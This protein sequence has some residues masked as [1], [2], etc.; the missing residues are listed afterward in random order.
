GN[1]R[2]P[3]N[4]P[5][6]QRKQVPPIG[7]DGGGFLAGDLRPA[8]RRSDEAGVQSHRRPPPT[9][10][11]CR[12]DGPVGKQRRQRGGGGPGGAGRT[13]H[14]HHRRLQQ[15]RQP[16]RSAQRYG[17]PL[18]GERRW[19]CAHRGQRRR[20]GFGPDDPRRRRHRRRRRAAQG[21]GRHRPAGRA[22]QQRD[23]AREQQLQR[24][25]RG[26]GQCRLQRR[27]LWTPRQRQ[28]L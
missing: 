20:A 15:E 28:R 12:D 16:Y 25:G 26:G 21:R 1:R 10:A 22:Q 17:R 7:G 14:F 8:N 27:Q 23:G 18:H 2:S 6:R 4:Q 3:R 11:G 13:E 9:S 19:Q 24:G 5:Q